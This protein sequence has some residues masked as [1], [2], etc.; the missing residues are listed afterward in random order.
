MTTIQRQTGMPPGFWLG[1]LLLLIALF[2][3]LTCKG[4]T[5]AK[6][7]TVPVRNECVQKIISQPTKNNNP[8]LFVVYND[9]RNEVIDL[10]PISESVFNYITL[11]KQNGIAPSLGIRLKDGQIISIIRYKPRYIRRR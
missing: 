7:D 3:P 1:V 8:K 11:C 9:T 10:I 2:L 6:Y 4:K 5:T